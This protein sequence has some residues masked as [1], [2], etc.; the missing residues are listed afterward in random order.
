MMTKKL[1]KF[2]VW[3]EQ[4]NQSYVDVTAS[5]RDVAIEK[6]YSKWRRYVAHSRVSYIEEIDAKSAEE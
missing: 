3:I 1:K 4:V 6:G 2:R 5:S